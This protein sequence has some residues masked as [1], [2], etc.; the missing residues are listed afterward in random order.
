M[1]PTAVS[2]SALGWRGSPASSSASWPWPCSGSSSLA[3]NPGTTGLS[4]D[5]L[6]STATRKENFLSEVCSIRLSGDEFENKMSKV[7]IECDNN[8]SS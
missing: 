4:Q 8:F 6:T 7:M 1:T 5:D 3:A 2:G